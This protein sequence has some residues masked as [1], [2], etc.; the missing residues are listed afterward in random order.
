[1]TVQTGAAQALKPDGGWLVFDVKAAGHTPAANIGDPEGRGT[2]F[3]G[4]SVHA[5]LPSGAF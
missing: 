1:M 2:T 4:F 3:Y 5:C